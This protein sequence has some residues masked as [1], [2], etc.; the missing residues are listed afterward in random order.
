MKQLTFEDAAMLSV[1][2]A[3]PA[4]VRRERRV[5]VSSTSS[6]ETPLPE[7]LAPTML[8]QVPTQALAPTRAIGSELAAVGR[9]LRA[10]S[11]LGISEQ[12]QA[13]VSEMIAESL[14]KATT[15][16]LR[17]LRDAAIEQVATNASAAWLSTAWGFLQAYCVAHEFVFC[18]DL[19]RAGLEQPREPRALGPVVLRAV[20]EGMLIPTGV[21]RPSVHSRMGQK[22]IWRSTL[23]SGSR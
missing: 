16:R 13:V 15:K 9:E 8:R 10:V 11:A 12:A 5:S 7:S 17:A 4:P 2:T 23:W 22:P 1:G 3:C 6:S 20:R 14:P 18:D 21:F 19:W